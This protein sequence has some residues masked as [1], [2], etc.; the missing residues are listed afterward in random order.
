[1]DL[2]HRATYDGKLHFD[3]RAKFLQDVQSFKGEPFYIVLRKN[4]NED[5]DYLR[6]YYWK[7][8]VEGFSN[9]VGY[10]KN[11][12]H[13]ILKEQYGLVEKEKVGTK[14]ER[15][16]LETAIEI[17]KKLLKNFA[18]ASNIKEIESSNG[19]YIEYVKG[20]SAMSV[21]ERIAYHNR[22]REGL[23]KECNLNLPSEREVEV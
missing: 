19:V 1:M 22:C 4:L 13:E 16:T 20:Y 5:P 6:R 10:E 23:F 21:P 14:L 18:S 17:T 9:E 8:I 2:R 12:A 11:E 15:E 7:V 3:D